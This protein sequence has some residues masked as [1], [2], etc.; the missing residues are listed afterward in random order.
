MCT[1]N[2][3]FSLLCFLG[4]LFLYLGV[5]YISLNVSYIYSLEGETL[6]SVVCA[7]PASILL[8]ATYKG[9]TE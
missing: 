6:G 3:L 7:I 5:I 4:Y 9:L 2:A 8:S 1:V